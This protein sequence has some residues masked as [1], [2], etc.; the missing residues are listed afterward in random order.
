M[1]VEV[2][3]WPLK[4]YSLGHAAIMVDGGSPSGPMYL[5]ANPGSMISAIYGPAVY[6]SYATDLLDGPPMVVRLTKLNETAIKTVAKSVTGFAHYSLFIGNCATQASICLNAG[7]TVPVPLVINTPAAL[8]A[9]AQTLR[10]LY[11]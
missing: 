6:K 8:F 3:W 5:S 9:Y 1:A 10:I 11:A 7:L 4:G 2:Y